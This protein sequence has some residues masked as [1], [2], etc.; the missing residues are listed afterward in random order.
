MVF[1]LARF[2]GLIFGV[3]FLFFWPIHSFFPLIFLL[4]HTLFLFFYFFVFF[5]N[6]EPLEHVKDEHIWHFINQSWN[7]TP[8]RITKSTMTWAY[9][10]WSALTPIQGY[11]GLWRRHLWRVTPIQGYV[12]SSCRHF[13]RV[14]GQE[15]LRKGGIQNGDLSRECSYWVR[16]W[17]ALMVL[18]W[19][20]GVMCPNGFV[21]ASP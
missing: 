4:G 18:I 13:W 16:V 1:G 11:V 19:M 10:H 12:G 9:L 15:T 8:R 21:T 7:M 3:H 2:F 5:Q 14:S 20:M 17:W 6:M